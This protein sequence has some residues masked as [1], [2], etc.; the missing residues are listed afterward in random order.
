ME[1][2]NWSKTKLKMRNYKLPITFDMEKVWSYCYGRA[3]QLS[4]V[5]LV[6]EENLLTL[7]LNKHTT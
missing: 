2:D 3:I 1:T 5:L 4:F 6:L 7:A